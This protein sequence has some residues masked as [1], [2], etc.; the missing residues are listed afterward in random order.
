VS[1]SLGSVGKPTAWHH[2]IASSRIGG[3]RM[4]VAMVLRVVVGVFLAVNL[5]RPFILLSSTV[6]SMPWMEELQ[7]AI[8]MLTY[9]C[10]QGLWDDELLVLVVLV[11]E[12]WCRYDW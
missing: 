1:L 10:C 12:V 3:C 7:L 8:V 4:T 11:G 6:A 9:L 2:A 5:C